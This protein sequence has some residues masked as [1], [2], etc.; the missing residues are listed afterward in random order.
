[1]DNDRKRQ[2]DEL[3]TT[4][5]DCSGEERDQ[6]LRDTGMVDKDLENEVRH[7][8]RGGLE[9]DSFLKL[10][11]ALLESALGE[12][13]GEIEAEEKEES[14]APIENQIG[15]YRI[16]RQIGRGGMG[17]VYL[18]QR[19][20]T[21]DGPFLALKV[22][23]PGFDDD[24][25]LRRFEQERHILATLDHSAIARHID[26]GVTGDGR[27]YFVMEYVDGQPVDTFCDNH[28]LT[29][30]QRL[31]LFL[32]VARAVQYAHRSMVVHRDLKPS[33][34]LVTEAHHVKLLD[35][36]IAKLIDQGAGAFPRLHHSP[37]TR[38][39]LRLMTP[40][41]ASPEQVRGGLVTTATD[42]YQLGVLLYE[43]LS[44]YPPYRVDG[45]TQAEIER[46]ICEH[47]P[48]APSTR[49]KRGDS[50]SSQTGDVSTEMLVS[51]NRRLSPGRLQARLRGDLDVIAL[52][53]LR[54][55]PERRYLSVDHLIQD[56]ERHLEGHAI[57]ARKDTGFYRATKFV[58]RHRIGLGA[59]I[60]IFVL[61]AMLIGFFVD[62][63]IAEHEQ[64]R[65]EA[66]RASQVVSFLEGL[67][68]VAEPGRGSGR[69]IS[70]RELLDHGV[71]QITSDLELQ[72]QLQATLQELLGDM[73]RKLGIYENARPLLE[74][75]LETRRKV[76]GD[77]HAD[78]A[79]SMNTCG[80]L[81]LEIGRYD[82]AVKLL[83]EAISIQQSLLAVES[84]LGARIQAN[85]AEV[86]V[87]TG[88]L[89][90]AEPFYQHALQ[91]LRNELG[92]RHQEI[93]KT[94]IGLSSLFWSEGRFEEAEPLLLQALDIL[95][96]AGDCNNRL[97]AI[98][99]SDLG[100]LHAL[101]GEYEQAEQLLLQGYSVLEKLLGRN[102][103]D[104]A[105]GLKAIARLKA[106]RGLLDEAEPLFEQVLRILQEVHQ[107]Q[108]P[109]IGECLHDIGLLYWD[110]GE[111]DEAE[112]LLRQAL[113]MGEATLGADHPDVA[114]GL[115]S[116]GALYWRLGRL[117]DAEAAYRRSIAIV[118]QALSHDHPHVAVVLV[119]LAS[120]LAAQGNNG[121]A[122][123]VCERAVVINEQGLGSPQSD[124]IYSRAVLAKLHATCGRFEQAETLLQVVLR[125]KEQEFGAEHPEL[126]STLLRL[127]R[128]SADQGRYDEALDYC[129]RSI[130]IGKSALGPNDPGVADSKIA[131]AEVLLLNDSFLKRAESLLRQAESVMIEAFGPDS[132]ELVPLKNQLA[133][134]LVKQGRAAE[135]DHILRDAAE[136]AMAK[137][138]RLIPDQR[139][140]LAETYLLLGEL[141][142]SS[143]HRS[144]ATRF[145]NAALA[146][147]DPY[148]GNSCNIRWLRIHA[149]TLIHLGRGDEARPF[150]QTLVAKGYQHPDLGEPSA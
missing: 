39:G 21:P 7:L 126:V 132:L 69:A 94:L 16:V 27:S 139:F 4:V 80:R 149:L 18:A 119:N 87:A 56:I 72:P 20:D 123:T 37:L 52:K 23:A 22:L 93:A 86:F 40:E 46:V 120:V 19:A 125:D 14:P 12:L 144:E 17:A 131:L 65:R 102:H 116:L 100:Q 134:V 59:G 41:Y 108:H 106:E 136:L 91:I 90:E 66:E 148:L 26:G 133:K 51:H 82:D 44:G 147:T 122:T 62:R 54:K 101:R 43:L 73:Y 55:E 50:G 138:G 130:K 29:L 58:Q 30:E 110:R 38:I 104:T 141:Q 24:D 112:K 67:F 118:E 135:V 1:M 105:I 74:Q 15:P 36:G 5:L 76:Q 83:R 33:N 124:I 2:V 95:Q 121:E 49:V 150:I 10:A 68:D 61:I 63:Q 114:A 3:L 128:V 35:F 142:Q 75:A 103:P 81:Y 53:A 42:V 129:E 84:L 13:I 85:L 31:R 89:E 9:D 47:E 96:E 145:W 146:S 99:L 109:D 45:C 97:C 137:E 127:C 79:A 88:K 60:A 78:V 70:A 113:D 71:E 64:T 143:G 11:G 98:A 25:V 92:P 140:D 111:Y 115:N 107:G 32:E 34:I 77:R 48:V 6:V 117:A 28:R 8:L 57:S